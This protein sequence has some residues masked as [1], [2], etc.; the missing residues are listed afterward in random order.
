M[1]NFSLFPHTYL[2]CSLIMHVI[3]LLSL[4]S[5]VTIFLADTGY[6]SVP[7]SLEENQT[8]QNSKPKVSTRLW[9]VAHS[10][11][12]IIDS[13]PNIQHVGEVSTFC[14][15]FSE[16]FL[17]QDMK[18]LIFAYF[19]KKCQVALDTLDPIE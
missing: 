7:C 6:S 1:T 12:A 17:A 8:V 4:L 18:S 15:F 16:N 13:L 19:L 11:Y 10:C 14:I 2:S 3:L 9:W 5:F